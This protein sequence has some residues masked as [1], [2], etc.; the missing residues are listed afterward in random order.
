MATVAAK[1]WK[2][3]SKANQ[4][5]GGVRYLV[6]GPCGIYVTVDSTGD[7]WD[8]RT[9]R[10]VPAKLSGFVRGMHADEDQLLFQAFAV[11]RNR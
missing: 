11:V 4:I 5:G 8:N 3:V 1:G 7:N 9:N 10:F 2:I 6:E